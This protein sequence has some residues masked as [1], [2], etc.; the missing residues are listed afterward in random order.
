[1]NFGRILFLALSALRRNK[2]RTGLTMLGIAIGVLAVIATLAVGRGA[3]VMIYTQL[4]SMGRNILL[5]LP[6]ASM[7]RGFSFGAGSSTSITPGDVVA[8][9][10]QVRSVRLAAPMIRTR[11]TLVNGSRNWIPMAILGTSPAFLEIRE[12]PVDEGVPFTEEQVAAGARVCLLGRTVAAQLFP[13]ESPIQE[14]IRIRNMPFKVAGILGRKGVNLMGM[15]QDDLIIVPWTTTKAT[16]LGSSFNNLHQILLSTESETDLPDAAAEITALLRQRHRLDADQENDFTVLTMTE[17]AGVLNQTAKIMTTLLGSLAS[18]ALLVGGIGIMN[19][20]L[21][22]VVQRTHEIGLRMAVGARRRDI[23]TQ[24]LMEAAVLSLVAGSAGSLAGVAAAEIITRTTHW[25]ISI[26]AGSLALA[27]A[28]ATA[29][30]LF[31]GFYPALRA[32]RLD[33]VDALRYE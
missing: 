31:F 25:P 5:V 4:H 12:W 21:V 27:Y 29:V 10:G 18:I 13:D 1:M 3:S 6:E 23:L 15:D 8:I 14:T 32:S 24:F 2:V 33:P 16:L 26:S 19:V 17:M 7:L 11:E 9:T 28:F 20:M 30:G 22:S